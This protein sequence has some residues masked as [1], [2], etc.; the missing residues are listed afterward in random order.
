MLASRQREYTRWLASDDKE[1]GVSLE[2]FEQ[3]YK[4]G[5][6][7][8]ASQKKQA[9]L[10]REEKARQEEKK[11]SGTGRTSAQARQALR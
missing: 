5:W 3:K 4:D 6:E 2:V 10:E 9:R 8:R 1:D 7:A 11:E